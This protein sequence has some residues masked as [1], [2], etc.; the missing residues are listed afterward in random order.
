MTN[1]VYVRANMDFSQTVL[2][3]LE[4][5]KKTQKN[6]PKIFLET[7]SDAPLDY[8]TR[9]EIIHTVTHIMLADLK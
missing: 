8:G 4:L 5:K 6:H 9:S 2:Q 3:A 1:V 7:R